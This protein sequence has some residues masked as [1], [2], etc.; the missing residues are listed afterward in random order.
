MFLKQK[1]PFQL[2]WSSV[3]TICLRSWTYEN[4]ER[5]I[6]HVMTTISY[7]TQTLHARREERKEYWINCEIQIT[8]MRKSMVC[9]AD[10]Q[11]LFTYYIL[12]SE[13]LWMVNSNWAQRSFMVCQKTKTS[14]LKSHNS[15]WVPTLQASAFTPYFSKNALKQ[16]NR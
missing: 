7:R 4:Q 13:T 1:T 10:P 5:F 9:I 12:S 14:S 15:V 8:E 2:K 3:K 6:P 11:I 16:M